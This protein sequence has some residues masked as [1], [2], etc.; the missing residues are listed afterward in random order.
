MPLPRCSRMLSVVAVLLLGLAAVS[1]SGAA[2]AQ[3]AT[4]AADE[5]M[6][7]Q[8]GVSFELV[9]LA[10]GVSAFDPADL[11]VVRI[12]LE[13]GAVST[14]DAEDPYGGIL[15]VESGA[16]TATASK[17]WT[18]T[19]GAGLMDAMMAAEESGDMSDVY[20]TIAAGDEATLEAGDAAYIP[21]YV[22]G[23]M[24][25]DGDEPASGLGFLIGPAEGMMGEA[26]PAP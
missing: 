24:R 9:T 17:P 8:E 18:V 20:E 26:T 3:D 25:N 19:R 11:V 23:E 13:P 21:G 2:R 12:G 7:M 22:D 16:I 15:L 1:W 10:P 5:S 14:F 4:P 6:M